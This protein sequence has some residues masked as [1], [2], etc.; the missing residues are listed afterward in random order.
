MSDE[1]EGLRL[2]FYDATCRGRGPL[3]GLT[4]AWIAGGA[5][6]KT[7]RRVDAWHGVTRWSE[8]LD[9]LL[10]VSSGRRIAEIQ[11]WGHGQWGGLWIENE[12]IQ[13]DVLNPGHPLYDRFDALRSRMIPRGRALWWFRCCDV[14]G[15]EVGHEFAKRW[16][17]FFDCRAAG[18]TYTINFLQSGLHVLE[19]GAEPHWP[20]HEGVL[21]WMSHAK[22][23]SVLAPNTITCLRGE[24]PPRFH[25]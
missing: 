3:P 16:T 6:Y 7:L 9:W 22:E 8:A 19:P 23:S 10:H 21:P 15:T 1:S 17:R 4:H 5:L 13:I 2:M 25:G 12:L 18:H 14:F 24:I 20:E 11:Y